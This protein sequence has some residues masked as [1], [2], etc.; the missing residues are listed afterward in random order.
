VQKVYTE[1]G[2]YWDEII[3]ETVDGN[4]T[5]KFECEVHFEISDE[6]RNNN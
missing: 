2:V 1:E 6:G 4:L 3:V 5:S